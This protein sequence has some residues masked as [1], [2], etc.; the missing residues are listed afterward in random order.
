MGKK[1]ILDG[2]FLSINLMLQRGN[3]DT[4]SVDLRRSV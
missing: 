4:G 2:N 1:N 3:A